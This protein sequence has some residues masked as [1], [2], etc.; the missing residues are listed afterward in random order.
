MDPHDLMKS[1][2]AGFLENLLKSEA[3]IP[4]IKTSKE[5]F[6]KWNPFEILGAYPDP[7]AYVMN[8]TYNISHYGLRKD[9]KYCEKLDLHHLNHPEIMFNKDGI[10]FTDFFKASTLYNAALKYGKVPF[11]RTLLDK[12]GVLSNKTNVIDNYFPHSQYI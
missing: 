12:N 3:D 5:D 10:I 4:A 1:I 11:H 6:Y 9:E 7:S 8:S 2:S